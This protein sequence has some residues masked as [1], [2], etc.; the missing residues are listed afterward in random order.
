MKGKISSKARRI[1]ADRDAS[2]KLMN[3]I[4][5]GKEGFITVNGQKYG[6][7]KVPIIRSGKNAS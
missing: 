2:S 1:F 3:Y 7:K 6:V 4:V 5:H